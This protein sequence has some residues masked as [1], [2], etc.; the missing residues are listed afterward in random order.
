MEKNEL[1]SL[2]ANHLNDNNQA[3]L[4]RV[5]RE[6]VEAY[7]DEA[8]GYAYLAEAFLLLEDVPFEKVE[9]CIAKAI[10]LDKTNTAYMLRFAYVKEVQMEFEDMDMIY[11]MV[12]EVDPNNAEALSSLGL[13]NLRSL[14]NADFAL[15]YFNRAI[16]GNPDN[17]ALY[18][19]RAEAYQSLEQI[20]EALADVDKSLS[21]Q[22][23][24][25]AAVLKISILKSLNRSAETEAIYKSLIAANPQTFTYPMD[26]GVDLLGAGRGQ[27]AEAYILQALNLVAEEERN[28]AVFQ[29]PLGEAYLYNGKYADALAIFE[30]CAIEEPEDVSL[31][32][33]SIDA[34]IGAGDL[35]GAMTDV[36][37]AIKLAKDDEFFADSMRVPKAEIY[38]AMGK[39]AEAKAVYAKLEKPLYEAE[40]QYGLGLIAHKQGDV[41]A[42]YQHLKNAKPL[43]E[44]AAKYIQANF[45]DYLKDTYQNLL[46]ENAAA[47][48]KNEQ[49]PVGQKLQGAIWQ[50]E[51]IK[52]PYYEDA[53]EEV[54]QEV[55]KNARKYSAIFTKQGMLWSMGDDSM[56]CFYRIEKE[57]DGLV[58]VSLLPID[59]TTPLVSKFKL[60]GETLTLN[61]REGEFYRTKKNTAVSDLVRN[62]LRSQFSKEQL[63]FLGADA[64]AILKNVF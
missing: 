31:T 51:S 58:Q 3:E 30:K 22:F 46:S 20:N 29:R 9:I 12:L 26:L 1:Q 45:T 63:S 21:M 62:E 47:F 42:A 39:Y 24:E 28:A 35:V 40:E 38:I 48:G 17:A 27:E 55:N 53:P 16:E 8:F 10:E 2:L 6:A 14:G 64:E 34:K 36:D 19:Y 13:Y 50:V 32:L 11:G 57:K 4:E 18:A 7:P 41:K 59:G 60:D 5:A 23:D 25:T 33:L 52:S 56:F 15:D 37:K 54:M 61:L 49:S 43:Y 44:K